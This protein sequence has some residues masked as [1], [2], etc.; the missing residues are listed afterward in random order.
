MSTDQTPALARATE[1]LVNEPLPREN[2]GSFSPERYATNLARAAVSAAL[3]DP[4]DPDFG[5]KVLASFDSIEWS[6]MRRETRDIYR[7]MFAAVRAA[8]LGEAS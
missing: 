2:D 8:I 1:A 4:D 5:A 6:N 7:R 3:H